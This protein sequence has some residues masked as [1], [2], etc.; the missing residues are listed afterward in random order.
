MEQ[1]FHSGGYD[2][3]VQLDKAEIY[4]APKLVTDKTKVGLVRLEVYKFIFK[5]VVST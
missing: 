4:L 5:D 2:D 1:G 3:K